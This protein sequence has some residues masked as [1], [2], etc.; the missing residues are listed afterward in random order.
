[1]QQVEDWKSGAWCLAALATADGGGGP[2]ARAAGELLAASGSTLEQLPP[3][4]TAEGM[5]A[6][7]TAVLTQ[8]A[9]VASTGSAWA[10]Q[11]DE[12]LLAQGRSSGQAAGI[13]R[14][15][16]LGHFDGLAD[17][18]TSPGARMLDV[19]T[20]CGYLALGFADAFPALHVVGIDVMP[21]VLALAES[22]VDGRVELRLQDVAT[23]DEVDV[24]DLVWLPA[25]F[26]PAEPLHA[27]LPRLVRALRPGGV[28]LVGHGKFT[29]EPVADALNRFVT[30]A[31]GGTPLDDAAAQQ[32]LSVAGLE[33][34]ATLAT[35]GPAP[36]LTVGRRPS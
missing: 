28:L 20:G 33:Q 22:V 32:L 36:A 30:V 26:V 15:V 27:A 3:G 19:G 6:A 5:R 17:R 25:P 10:E 23:I 24:Y 16:V 31:Y 2:L 1:M 29:G 12:A 14:D 21:R 34:V 9:Q 35:P 18:L 13:F 8:A 7:A 11:S 4:L